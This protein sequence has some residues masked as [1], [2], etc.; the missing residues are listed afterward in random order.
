M[1]YNGCGLTGHPHYY[2]TGKSPQCPLH[3]F[4]TAVQ[5]FK[6]IIMGLQPVKYIVECDHCHCHLMSDPDQGILAEISDP[7]ELLHMDIF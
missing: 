3:T 4:C 6:G 5:L 1:M 7:D 2:H